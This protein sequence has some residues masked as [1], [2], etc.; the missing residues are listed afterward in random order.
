[1]GC[2][3]TFGAILLEFMSLKNRAYRCKGDLVKRQYVHVH[4][5]YWCVRVKLVREN[6]CAF[7]EALG[8]R[9]VF[10]SAAKNEGM[11]I[12]RAPLLNMLTKLKHDELS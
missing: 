12:L 9:S 3:F 11:H 4:T 2:V 10:T 6:I 7:I 1:M 8:A 5:L